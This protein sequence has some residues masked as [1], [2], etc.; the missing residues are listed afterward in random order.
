MAFLAP[1][2][3]AIAGAI[4]FGALGTAVAQIA[5][6][7]GV[8]LLANKL[9]GKKSRGLSAST[10]QQLSLRIEPDA[11][12]QVIFGRAAT[13]GSLVFWNL[14]GSA[15]SR[16]HMVVALA[17]HECQGLNSTIWVDGKAQT[18]NSSTGVVSGYG[19]KLKVRFY[20]GAPGQTADAG[21]VAAAGVR[22]TS[23]DV[24]SGICYAVVE[25]D[26][27]QEVFAGGIPQIVFVVD[28]A[29]LYDPRKDTTAGGS[30]A[31]RWNNSA[32]WEWTDNPAVLVYNV[33]RGIRPGG[34]LL[35]GMHVPAEAI[36][37]ADF[38]AAANACDE[39]VALLASGSEKR[40]RCNLIA[41]SFASNADVLERIL[42]T[43]AGELIEVGGIYRIQAGVAQAIVGTLSDDDLIVDR[44]FTV[45]PRRPRSELI[46]AVSA[47]FSDPSRSFAS[48]PL[49]L[50]FSSADQAEDGGIRLPVTLDL[51]GV[52]SR[53]QAQRIM[54]IE[55]RR[56]RRQMRMTATFRKRWVGLEPGDWIEF[57]SARRGIVARTFE[58]VSTTINEDL[59][60]AVLLQETDAAID[61][62]LASNELADNSV[63]DLGP[64]GPPQA[65]VTGFALS[66]IVFSSGA[67][68]VQRP[69]LI[70][71]WT[72]VADP[73]V[74]SLVLQY[75]R[76]GDTTPIEE[77]IND[78]TSG[79]YRWSNGI[80]SA[81]VYEAR[82]RP[83]TQPARGFAWTPWAATS[84]ATGQQVVPVAAEALFIAPENLPPIDGQGLTA[85]E[86]FEL[87]LL[88][89]TEAIQGSVSERI[90][91][92]REDLERV[93]QT[94]IGSI[95]LQDRLIRGVRQTVDGTT[96]SVVELLEVTAGLSG[97][98]SIAVDVNGRVVGAVR[99][100]GSAD[101]SQF[102]VLAD[103]FVVSS[104]GNPD[105]VPF[106]VTPEGIFLE[107]AIVKDNSITVEKLNVSVLS[108]LTANLGDVTA[109]KLRRADNTMIIDLDAKEFRID[110]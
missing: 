33:L 61:D 70:A 2:V 28:G 20:S 50:R 94:L 75:R 103:N 59:S 53:T 23:Q 40:Y 11:E 45:D 63:V 62:W 76:V 95:A 101:T 56:A 83:V 93:S 21:L 37:F 104:P 89:A 110:F 14:S 43:M 31:H 10:G 13:A 68:G 105:V 9:T 72:P 29:K 22:W 77:T 82:I 51:S 99:L 49:P 85:Q 55:R 92:L 4:G 41:S 71:T 1:V 48:V 47:T 26:Y 88:T 81:T 46:N 25:A 52:T 18:W 106:A 42:A 100:D 44:P 86:R 107:G 65:V 17:D 5:V 66:T 102:T 19:G 60:I 35:L 34:E 67:A 57:S 7:V 32:T 54:E 38:V 8:S 98:W 3:G 78:P 12:R 109:G 73:T 90:S 84:G 87:Q 6:G 24:G 30:G 74:V 27:D 69:G 96:V 36:R 16:L 15:N 91:T 39:T 97:A 79:V 80:Q 108:A 64:A 58:V